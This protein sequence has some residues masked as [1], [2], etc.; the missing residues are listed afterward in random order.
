MSD[1]S[2]SDYQDPQDPFPHSED[3]SYD[4]SDDDL[5]Q[6]LF[7]LSSRLQKYC[8][9]HG[10]PIFN[11]TQTTTI[12]LNMFYASEAKRNIASSTNK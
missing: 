3:E 10:L 11:E 2:D 6:Q 9:D 5:M 12:I 8:R 1:L 4:D 7:N